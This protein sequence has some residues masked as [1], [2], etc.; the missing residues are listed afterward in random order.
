MAFALS[1]LI[2]FF[3]TPQP[4]A[5]GVAQWFV[6]VRRCLGKCPH[7]RARFSSPFRLSPRHMSCKALEQAEFTRVPDPSTGS[8]A[9]LGA[10]GRGGLCLAEHQEPALGLSLLPA[11]GLSLLPALGLSL[12]LLWV[13]HSSLSR[14]GLRSWLWEL[15][16]RTPSRSRSVQGCLHSYFL[17]VWSLEG[18]LPTIISPAVGHKAFSLPSCLLLRA[19]NNCSSRWLLS[20]AATGP[21]ALGFVPLCN[22]RSEPVL[23]SST[24]AT[25]AR[26]QQHR[27]C[28]EVAAADGCGRRTRPSL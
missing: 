26:A 7:T 24:P 9:A 2:P 21:R 15:D 10:A 11:L 14:R 28:G 27:A 19:C 4:V 5:H 23:L 17:L 6:E 18:P 3:L 22:P 12:L 16:G 8:W 25:R 20:L 1:P 13:C